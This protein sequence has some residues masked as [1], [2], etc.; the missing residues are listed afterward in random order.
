MVLGTAGEVFKRTVGL[1]EAAPS[2]S[3]VMNDANA[4]RLAATLC[5]MR[6]AA[7]KVG[8]M[9]SIQDDSMLPPVVR[10]RTCG[11]RVLQGSSATLTHQMCAMDSTVA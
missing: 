8:Q 7:L 1:S 6:G 10:R 4:E 2:A 5:R 11:S 3:Y 9:L